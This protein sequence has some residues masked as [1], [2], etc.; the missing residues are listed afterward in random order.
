M[1]PQRIFVLF[2]Y[3]YTTSGHSLNEVQ[4]NCGRRRRM[5]QTC[6]YRAIMHELPNPIS[7]PPGLVTSQVVRDVNELCALSQA[8]QKT[9]IS[10]P[11][12]KNWSSLLLMSSTLDALCSNRNGDRCW[13]WWWRWGLWRWQRWKRSM[14]RRNNWSKSTWHQTPIPGILVSQVKRQTGQLKASEF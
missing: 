6:A 1:S 14:T 9:S 10:T 11:K 7:S 8:Q 2:T 3:G 13:W 5:P 4:H 12:A